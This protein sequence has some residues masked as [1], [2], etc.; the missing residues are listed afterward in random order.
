MTYDGVEFS[1]EDIAANADIYG[2]AGTVTVVVGRV[3]A[4]FQE[5]YEEVRSYIDSFVAAID[6]R[7]ENIEKLLQENNQFMQT[8]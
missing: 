3:R 4:A 1:V 5:L 7:K 2:A 6:L 8:L